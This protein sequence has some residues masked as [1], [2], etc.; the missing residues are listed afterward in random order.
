MEAPWGLAACWHE[1]QLT[2]QTFWT[3]GILDEIKGDILEARDIAFLVGYLDDDVKKDD[4]Q[5]AEAVE[6]ERLPPVY[7]DGQT[8]L[9]SSVSQDRVVA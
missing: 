7:V 2:K 3:A 5:K 9:V 8:V 6:Q 4:K 1:Q